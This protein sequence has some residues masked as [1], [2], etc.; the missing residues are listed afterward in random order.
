[1]WRRLR[2]DKSGKEVGCEG[3]QGVS[4]ATTFGAESRSEVGVLKVRQSK[5][6]VVMVLAI[7]LWDELRVVP[8][9]I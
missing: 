2:Q 6:A 3:C 5:C 9:A 7:S 8:Y 4:S 1:V